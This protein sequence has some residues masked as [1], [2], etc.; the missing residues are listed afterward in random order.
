ME[1]DFDGKLQD[2]E[3]MGSDGRRSSVESMRSV[4]LGLARAGIVETVTQSS[5]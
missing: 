3:E 2:I 4:T 1:D 5:A